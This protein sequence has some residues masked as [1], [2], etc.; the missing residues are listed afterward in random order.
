MHKISDHSKCN[1][2]DRNCLQE[3]RRDGGR[4]AQLQGV[5]RDDQQQERLS[6][7]QGRQLGKR[8]FIIIIGTILYLL[9]ISTLKN[10]KNIIFCLR[11]CHCDALACNYFVLVL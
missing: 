7:G 2:A 3:V 8:A 5:L 6:T 4:G 9:K 1:I 10:A 11:F